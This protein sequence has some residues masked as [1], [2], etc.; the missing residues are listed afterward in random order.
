VATCQHSA[1][2]SLAGWLAGAAVTLAAVRFGGPPPALR[3]FAGVLSF[4]LVIAAGIWLMQWA[5]LGYW[6][7]KAARLLAG[8]ERIFT[9]SFD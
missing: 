6:M 1:A 9:L 4:V 3:P 8:H 7:I 5:H 2:E